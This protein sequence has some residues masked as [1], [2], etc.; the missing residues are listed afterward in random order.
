MRYAC[1]VALIAVALLTPI[2]ALS[3]DSALPPMI[4][5]VP[6]LEIKGD[7]EDLIDGIDI[8]FAVPMSPDRSIT[9][10]YVW[11][12]NGGDDFTATYNF[13]FPMKR[14]TSARISAGVMQDELGVGV[15]AHR[16]YE[17]YGAGAF[18][19][20][21]GGDIHAGIFLSTPL[22]W[23]AKLGKPVGKG[24]KG[25]AE[26][27]GNLAELGAIATVGLRLREGQ[28]AEFATG[29]AWYPRPTMDWPRLGK[30]AQSLA[31]SPLDFAPPAQA[32]W[33]FQT[34][35]PLRGGPAVGKDRVYVG[36]DDGAVH[37]IKLSDGTP[38]WTA[39]VGSEVT[40]ALTVSGDRVYV[41]TRAGHLVCLRPPMLAEG[42]VAVEEWRFGARGAITSCPL[43]TASGLVVF[44][45]DDGVCY[46]LDKKGRLVWSFK[47]RGPIVAAPSMSAR[48][49]AAPGPSGDAVPRS[50]LI[51]CASTDGVLYALRE[52]D[53]KP[54]WTFA[55]ES[56]LRAAPAVLDN[57]VVVGNEEGLVYAVAAAS[58][59]A[60]WRQGLGGPANTSPAVADGRAYFACADGAVVAL[61]INDGK[62]LWTSE[63]FGQV[64]TPPIATRS[65]YLVVVSEAGML[66]A[67]RRSDGRVMWAANTQERITAA[68]AV[69]GQYLVFGS[70]TGRVHAYGRGGKWRIDPPP[71]VLADSQEMQTLPRKSKVLWAPA[72]S[73][74]PAKP[75][76]P[77]ASLQDTPAEPTLRS[78]ASETPSSDAPG[79]FPSPTTGKSGPRVSALAKQVSMTL[80]T[81]ANDPRQPP[82]QIAD[83]TSV[84]ISGKVPPDTRMVTVN[85]ELAQMAAGAFR[86]Q[87]TFRE[88][89]AYPVTIERLDDAGQTHVNRR[90]LMVSPEERPT[91]AAPVFFSPE[92]ATTGNRVRFT[93]AAERE[94]GEPHVTVL[95]IRDGK[96]KSIR[97]WAHVANEPRTFE[98]DGRD[99]TGRR[100]AAGVYF[101]EIASKQATVRKKLVLMH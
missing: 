85:D 29:T 52:R 42:I 17:S 20:L 43:V 72:Q 56:A 44:G 84:V 40:S 92:A 6:R 77:S 99:R 101:Y 95:E 63:V 94:S 73:A 48:R 61:D 35:G 11:D 12:F 33:T 38:L 7:S 3:Q 90:I 87:L 76:A 2:P 53:G 34:R 78:A 21:V 50:P 45:S 24:A 96:G 32:A 55:T 81:T 8:G 91:S 79:D 65:R 59:R 93:L 15:S 51:S 80:L 5:A 37:A 41:G 67:M 49:F 58:G 75:L 62:V 54:A 28:E 46:A 89:G 18:A 97:A 100:A 30:S 36:G 47:T 27:Q 23:G 10:N 88:A 9:G 57:V 86:A 19:N 66:Y 70:D 4:F 71:V 68:A 16:L 26:A 13:E 69:A 60:L 22:R 74:E 25:R 83:R 82:I 39:A 14:L 31:S 64:L 98:W 1:P